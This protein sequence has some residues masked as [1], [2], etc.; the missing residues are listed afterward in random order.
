[1]EMFVFTF[2]DTYE[3]FY[4]AADGNAHL[5]ASS[6]ANMLYREGDGGVYVRVHTSESSEEMYF[7]SG[8]SASLV[9]SFDYATDEH[10]ASDDLANQL[11]SEYLDDTRAPDTF[12]LPHIFYEDLITLDEKGLMDA[13][14][15][16]EKLVEKRPNP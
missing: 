13:L 10:S 12:D 5:V 1:M 15:S 16:S 9:M 11:V 14:S 6:V 4:T 3:S 2:D 7:L 8:S